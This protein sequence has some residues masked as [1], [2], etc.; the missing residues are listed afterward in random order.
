MNVMYVFSEE[1]MD[2][3][4]AHLEALSQKPLKW[5]FQQ[6]TVLRSFLHRATK[7]IHFKAYNFSVI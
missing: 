3:T 6:T 4:G 2:D 5:L 7:L 1:T